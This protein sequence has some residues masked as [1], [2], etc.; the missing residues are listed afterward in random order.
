MNDRAG[1]RLPRLIVSSHERPPALAEP[2][3]T[4][5][6]WLVWV[7]LVDQAC[8]VVDVTA[9]HL[10]NIHVRYLTRC[11]VPHAFGFACTGQT[12]P[13]RRVAVVD[14]V[15]ADGGSHHSQRRFSFRDHARDAHVRGPGPRAWLA[16][17]WTRCLLSDDGGSYASQPQVVLRSDQ[18]PPS[19]ANRAD[20]D[21]VDRLTALSG[22]QE[23][24]PPAS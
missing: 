23:R 12:R 13:N 8:D 21:S 14:Q 5:D 15:T 3:R 17:S 4:N 2:L 18:A 6:A 1:I 11:Q 10:P 22:T 19:A 9:G 16:I 24:Q 7:G 20:A